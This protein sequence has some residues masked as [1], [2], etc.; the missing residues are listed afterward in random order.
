MHIAVN[1]VT[2]EILLK[3]NIE[4]LVQPQNFAILVTGDGNGLVF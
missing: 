2:M 3:I 1:A 4:G